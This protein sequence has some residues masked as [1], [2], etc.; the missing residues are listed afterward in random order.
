MW[1]LL[2]IA[3]IWLLAVALPFQGA[4]A[5]TMLACG[6]AH[7]GGAA[8]GPALQHLHDDGAGEAAVMQSDASHDHHHHDA[9]AASADDEG[10]SAAASSSPGSSKCSVCASCCT[11]SAL[12]APPLQFLPAAA[13][14]SIQ[15]FATS[16]PVAFLTGG[17]ERP[18][19]SPLA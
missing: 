12:P 16:Q 4:V 14:E 1:V 19:R 6:P 2:R 15:A 11:A 3:L 17:P 9:A 7:Q 10:A 18:P 13:S 5:A 8:H